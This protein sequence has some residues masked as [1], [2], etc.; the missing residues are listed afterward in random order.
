IFE[1][2]WLLACM[3]PKGDLNRAHSYKDKVAKNAE[4][5]RDPDHGVNMGLFN[6]PV[7]MAADILLY[8]S[9]QVPVGQDQKQ[10]VEIARSIAQR[11]N[12]YFGKGTLV[13]PQEVIGKEGAYV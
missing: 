7:L 2:N 11:V 6:Y 12:E 5:G 1:L 4:E 9:N 8:D 10:H 13:E 3:T